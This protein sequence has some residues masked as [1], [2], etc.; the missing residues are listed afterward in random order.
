M[1][2]LRRQYESPLWLLLTITGLVLLIAWAN[3]AN[4]L[5]ARASAREKEIAVRI[6]L[7]AARGR[8]V[9]QLFTESLLLALLGAALGMGLARMLSSFLVR[10][11][12]REGDV[13]HIF[14]GLVTD[15]RVFGRSTDPNARIGSE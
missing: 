6:A 12:S 4:L 11:L 7:G 8:I 15:W 10:Y 9:R 3:L 2:N 5:L 13:R 1:S 14:V